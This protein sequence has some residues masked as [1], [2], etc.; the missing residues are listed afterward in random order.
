ME[1]K[2]NKI[3][4]V[5]YQPTCEMLVSDFASK[6]Q[7]RLPGHLKLHSLKLRETATA[8]AEWYAEDNSYLESET[9]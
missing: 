6:I 8:Y 2:G 1:E 4:R 3:V 5:N 9:I 7:V